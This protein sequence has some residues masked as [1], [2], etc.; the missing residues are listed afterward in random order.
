MTHSHTVNTWKRRP[1]RLTRFEVAE[2][3]EQFNLSLE[4]YRREHDGRDMPA[5]DR[6]ALWDAITHSKA[7]K[8]KRRP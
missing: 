7:G 1:G 2:R 4:Q 8:P 3:R 5:S 6:A